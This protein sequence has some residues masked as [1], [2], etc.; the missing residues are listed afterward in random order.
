MP[1]NTWEIH[2]PLSGVCVSARS[3]FNDAI[4]KVEVSQLSPACTIP[5]KKFS[6]LF[7]SVE[8]CCNFH[9]KLFFVFELLFKEEE[10]FGFKEI[11]AVLMQ[12]CTVLSIE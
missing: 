7:C 6:V 2:W 9:R 10:K 4:L 1:R 11:L 8:E 5:S 12:F 3:D